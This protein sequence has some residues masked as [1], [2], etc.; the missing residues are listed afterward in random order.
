MLLLTAA[1]VQLSLLS[2]SALSIVAAHTSHDGA[3]TR[4]AAL[5]TAVCEVIFIDFYFTSQP[6][7]LSLLFCFF[8]ISL[9]QWNESLVRVVSRPEWDEK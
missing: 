7:L 9:V 8:P 1:A 4:T 5:C 2:D 3:R 6:H